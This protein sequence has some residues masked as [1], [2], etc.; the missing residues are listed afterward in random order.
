MP[1][2]FQRP[3]LSSAAS[4]PPRDDPGMNIAL[5]ARKRLSGGKEKISLSGLQGLSAEL[6]KA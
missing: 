4:G 5:I 1:R 6:A 3:F 2:L